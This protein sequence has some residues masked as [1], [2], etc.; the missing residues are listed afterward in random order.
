MTVLVTG[1]AGFIGGVVTDQLRAGGK[2]VVVIDDLSRGHR[3]VVDDDVPFYRATVGD[4]DAITRIV[5]DHEVDACIHFA[6]LIA[7]G[8]SVAEPGLY[9]RRNVAES[10]TLFDT[11]SSLGVDNVVFSSSAAVYGD[12]IQVPIPEAHPKQPTSPY[13]NT[14][15]VVELVLEDLSA[16]GQLEAVSLRYFNAA[17][18]SERRRERH[19]PE[20]HLIPLALRAARDGT[21]M[22]VF[23]TDYPTPDGTAIRDYIHVNDLASAHVR[24]IDYL[25]SGGATV[26]L[27][28]GVGHGAS[29][30]EVLTTSEEVTGL[31]I[32]AV[33]TPRRPG[34]P[35]I[36]VAAADEARSIL[37]W[38]PHTTDL[39]AI[40]ESAWR[41]EKDGP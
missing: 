34:D 16:A 24:A 37:Q 12:P 10:I 22:N 20:T 1:G 35:A 40:V 21:P 4:R 36:L 7:V 26:A 27:N 17:G 13:G 23:G 3:D 28:L 15:M 31:P 11:L 32:N 9:W 30:R 8:E 18:A 39:G 14:K 41:W 6:G 29:V 33:E 25:R 38:T 19:I 2:P 5:A